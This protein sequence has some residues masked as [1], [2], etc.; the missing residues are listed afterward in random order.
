[1]SEFSQN[2]LASRTT[3]PARA[4]AVANFIADLE[5][6]CAPH[7]LACLTADDLRGYVDAKLAAGFHASTIRKWLAMLRAHYRRLYDA[8]AVTASTYTAVRSVEMPPDTSRHGPNPY[9]E[10]EIA[11]LRAIVDERWPRL[12]A[13][14]ARRWLVRWRDRRSPYSR[15]RV[16]AIRCQLDA[17]IALALHC[18]LRKAEILRLNERSMHTDNEGVVVWDERGPWEGDNREVPYSDEARVLIAPWMNLRAAIAP[19]HER[20]WLNL[21]AA[22]T[23]RQPMSE[24]TFTRLLATYVGPGWTL[25]RLR[26]TCALGWVKER[27]PAL[28]LVERLGLAVSSIDPFLALAPITSDELREAAQATEAEFMRLV[29]PRT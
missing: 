6:W 1:M 25:R 15:I 18:G 9:T 21:H 26:D 5:A 20:P 13:T 17:I 22:P 16:H 27:L 19:G 4:A 29:G 23:V 28:E 11:E 8:G 10:D 3:S 2:F 24:A 14:D 7:S 12:S